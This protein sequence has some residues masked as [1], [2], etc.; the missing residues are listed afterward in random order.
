M[1]A[2]L[3]AVI[4]QVPGCELYITF[5]A[6]VNIAY[7]QLSTGALKNISMI[8]R[9]AAKVFDYLH[10]SSTQSVYS[11]QYLLN[12]ARSAR[13]LSVN[14]ALAAM[15]ATG[16]LSINATSGAQMALSTLDAWDATLGYTT[17]NAPG[18]LLTTMF[19]GVTIP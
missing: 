19:E 15:V 1:L 17:P 18:L 4:N 14:T 9:N 3:N 11:S 10:D 6:Q 5:A 2:P 13:Q 16:V 8:A 7:D 12:L